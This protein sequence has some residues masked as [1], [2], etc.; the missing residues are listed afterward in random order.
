MAPRSLLH[1]HSCSVEAQ[2]AGPSLGMEP[3]FE[4]EGNKGLIGN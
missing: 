2:E 4:A 1:S 3:V